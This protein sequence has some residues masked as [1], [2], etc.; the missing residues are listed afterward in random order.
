MAHCCPK[1]LI[2]LFDDNRSSCFPHAKQFYHGVLLNSPSIINLNVV[3]V[4]I[5]TM[6]R[7]LFCEQ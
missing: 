1:M 3:A 5:T 7:R 6:I 4:V 2:Q